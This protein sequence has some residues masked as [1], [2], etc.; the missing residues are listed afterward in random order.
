[1]RPDVVEPPVRSSAAASLDGHVLDATALSM[2]ARLCARD[3]AVPLRRATHGITPV[4][5]VDLGPRRIPVLVHDGAGRLLGVA[6]PR[7]LDG[8]GPRPLAAVDAMIPLHRL[9]IASGGDCATVLETPLERDGFALVLWRGRLLAAEL[10][11]VGR[12]ARVF[13]LLAAWGRARFG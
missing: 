4:G 11:D 3:V 7:Q 10:D 1:M 13:G 6:G 8:V 12:Q 5:A 2:L 9:E